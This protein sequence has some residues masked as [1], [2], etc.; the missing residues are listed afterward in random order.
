[1][2]TQPYPTLTY[3]PGFTLVEFIIVIVISGIVA[4]MMGTF[5]SRPMQSYI[6]LNRRAELV[7]IADI[8]LRRIARDVRR[9]LPNSVR[10]SAAGSVEALEI[11]NVIDGARY[12]D[13][14]P[15]NV[16]DFSSAD[17]QFEVLGHL[18][19]I[20]TALA[21]AN[22][23]VV[24]YNT[25]TGSGNAY[26]GSNTAT[27]SNAVDLGNVDELTITNAA[28]TGGNPAFPTAS[29]GQRFFIID[30]PISYLCDTSA[31]T[32]TRYWNYTINATQP[33]T[34]AALLSAGA[35]SALLASKVSSCNAFYQAGVSQRTGLVTL[36]LTISSGNESVTLLHQSHVDNVP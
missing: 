21:C 4:T 26:A 36:E 15:G 29:P 14:P 24:V 10:I 34:A 22:C 3:S 7:D 31:G 32:I 11:L 13:E 23:L 17:G 33:T 28:L 18:Q 1:M 12:R 27:L 2:A 6:D 5:I 30:T 8:T 9:A 19:N 20:A 35:S 16:L 25:G